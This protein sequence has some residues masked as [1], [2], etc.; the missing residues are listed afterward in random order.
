MPQ[1]HEH[2]KRHGVCEIVRGRVA[3]GERDKRNLTTLND[4]KAGSL[5]AFDAAVEMRVLQAGAL[6][7]ARQMCSG[8]QVLLRID[9]TA[10]TGSN[11][12][13]APPIGVRRWGQLGYELLARRREG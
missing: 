3:V 8:V 1:V 13:G 6:Y 12:S 9:P 2:R 11:P 7:A 4:N 10:Q 5:N